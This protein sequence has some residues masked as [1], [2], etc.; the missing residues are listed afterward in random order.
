[1]MTYSKLRNKLIV[2]GAIIAG[3]AV[4]ALLLRFAAID[5]LHISASMGNLLFAAGFILSIWMYYGLSTNPSISPHDSVPASY[6]TAFGKT[7]LLP[8]YSY[9]IIHSQYRANQIRYAART[10]PSYAEWQH[11]PMK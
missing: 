1:M 9:D 8:L 6:E 10:Q 11:N 4:T 2:N 7:I 5:E 3:C